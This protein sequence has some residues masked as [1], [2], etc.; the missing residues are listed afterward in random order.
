MHYIT[1]SSQQPPPK[2]GVMI[3]T[4]LMGKVR[5]AAFTY[6]SNAKETQWQRRDLNVVY[7]IAKPMFLTT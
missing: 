3:P 1:K 5:L 2:E 4:V 6:F 7:L